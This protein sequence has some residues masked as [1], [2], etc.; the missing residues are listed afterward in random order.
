M[1][2]WISHIG[3]AAGR[4]PVVGPMAT[5]LS[6]MIGGGAAAT[7]ILA[8]GAAA[9]TAAKMMT[10]MTNAHIRMTEEYVKSRRAYQ[11]GGAYGAGLAPTGLGGAQAALATTRGAIGLG[12]VARGIEE[13]RVREA[14]RS[15]ATGA[16][17]S[18]QSAL[19]A[20]GTGP[21]WGWEQIKK[22]WRAGRG[23][24]GA[25]VN[26]SAGV[27]PDVIAR[28]TE[29]QRRQ[30]F[31]ESIE[32]RRNRKLLER[33]FPMLQ[34]EYAR[35]TAIEGMAAP[36]GAVAVATPANP[37]HRELVAKIDQAIDAINRLGGG[38]P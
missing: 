10:R 21:K 12:G 14:E 38:N 24:L 37:M 25:L 7:G 4:V 27:D 35:G 34:H 26:W 17:V 33:A 9:V 22:G 28:E 6:G 8:L 31:G 30:S 19:S 36:A 23:G 13:R 16:G 15:L 29:A 32:A 18:G 20:L 11:I 3:G 1:A 2:R 5:Q